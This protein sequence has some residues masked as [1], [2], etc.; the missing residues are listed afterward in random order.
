MDEL[1]PLDQSIKK[2]GLRVAVIALS[3]LFSG[4]SFDE[5][6][7]LISRLSSYDQSVINY[8]CAVLAAVCSGAAS[9]A[10]DNVT[11]PK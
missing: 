10:S 4:A 5:V 8:A 2:A 1:T 6:Y 7:I 9:S 11:Y 3:A